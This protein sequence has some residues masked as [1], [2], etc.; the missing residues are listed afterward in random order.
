MRLVNPSTGATKPV[1]NGFE[2]R[3]DGLTYTGTADGQL[4]RVWGN[5]LPVLPTTGMYSAILTDMSS[6]V[7]PTNEKVTIADGAATMPTTN[8]WWWDGI[9]L[10]KGAHVTIPCIGWFS[11]EDWRIMQALH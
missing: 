9:L 1:N 4:L 5:I 6:G 2:G 7:T 8:G 11:D 3:T 10:A